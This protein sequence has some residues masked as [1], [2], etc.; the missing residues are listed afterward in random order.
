MKKN[1]NID[2]PQEDE[3]AIIY[4]YYSL[5]TFNSIIKN[6]ELWFSDIKKMNDKNED[7]EI[8]LFLKKELREIM[9]KIQKEEERNKENTIKKELI[10]KITEI[11]KEEKYKEYIREIK[12]LS[13]RK[14]PNYLSSLKEERNKIAGILSLKQ[15]QESDKFISCFSKQGDLL[16]Q[17][18]SYADDGKG[19]CIGFKLEK[20]KQIFSKLPTIEKSINNINYLDEDMSVKKILDI[21]NEENI[22]SNILVESF[23]SILEDVND[24]FERDFF[25]SMLGSDFFK[26]VAE[27]Y[28]SNKEKDIVEKIKEICKKF[29]TSTFFK[30]SGF[31][32]EEEVRILIKKIKE[33]EESERTHI[34]KNN[35]R[36]NQKNDDFI[37]Y[38][39]LI[40]S[41]EDFKSSVSEIIIG[42]N[43]NIDEKYL[44]KFL[45]NQNIMKEKEETIVIKKSKIPYKN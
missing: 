2:K 9:I 32:E 30:H 34:S 22:F 17:W 23:G 18:R 19:I 14:D 31:K 41:E 5:S 43:N 21:F 33:S 27:K 24:E 8:F 11:A 10:D 20:L 36:I 16:G 44:R 45:E 29:K 4:Q 28:L 39:K 25:I 26:I 40:F 38:I 13:V 37:E 12:K 6:K 15:F 42:P 7:V 35:F 1:K 3:K